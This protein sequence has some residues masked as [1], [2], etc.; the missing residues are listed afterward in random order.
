VGQRTD[1]DDHRFHGDEFHWFFQ[2]NSESDLVASNMRYPSQSRFPG[3]SATCHLESGGF[4][5]G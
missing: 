4:D 2:R 3:K 5:D 1:S